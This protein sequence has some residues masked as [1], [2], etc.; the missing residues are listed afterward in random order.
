MASSGAFRCRITGKGKMKM[1]GSCSPKAG[2][3]KMK[4]IGSCSPKAG[5]GNDRTVR[6]IYSSRVEDMENG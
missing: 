5:K 6:I 3:E 2:T 4:A 1:I